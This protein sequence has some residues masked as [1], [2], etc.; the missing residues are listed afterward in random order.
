MLNVSLIFKGVNLLLEE[1]TFTF[2]KFE[3]IAQHSAR[4]NISKPAIFTSRPKSYSHHVFSLSNVCVILPV[5][6][7]QTK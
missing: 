5:L 1:N 4:G 6:P 3:R 2:K 7:P